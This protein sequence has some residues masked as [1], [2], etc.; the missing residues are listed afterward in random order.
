MPAG[1]C[2]SSAR[3]TAA[4]AGGRP[5]PSDDGKAI[6]AI[7]PSILVHPSN[8][9]EA[10]GRTRSGRIFE[11]WSTDAGRR[12]SAIALIDLPNPSAGIDAVSLADGRALLVYNHSASARS[13]LNVGVSRDGRAFEAAAV[14]EDQPGPEYSYPVVIQSRDGL[15]HVTYSWQGTRA[16]STWSWRTRRACPLD[17]LSEA[18][19][20]GSLCSPPGVSAQPRLEAASAVANL[21]AR[22]RSI[23]PT[24]AGE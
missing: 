16:S 12:W 10:L 15:V 18:S 11:A 5:P 1:A 19:G 14:L 7:Q 3:P 6:S 2:I 23:D 13:L 22:K 20:R 9:L 4:T 21:G 17:R 8:R 24:M